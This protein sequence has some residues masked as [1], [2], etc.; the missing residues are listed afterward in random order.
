MQLYML[1]SCCC[2]SNYFLYHDLEIIWSRYNLKSILII[3]PESRD[4]PFLATRELFTTTHD[5]DH[6]G[7]EKEEEEEWMVIATV[8]NWY[9]WTI[10]KL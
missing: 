6:E 5:D 8:V 9:N 2:S 4:N 1:G 7:N 3:D 10:M